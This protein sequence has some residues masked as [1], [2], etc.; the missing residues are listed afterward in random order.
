MDNP[1]A[2]DLS[3]LIVGTGILG[4]IIT[5]V[6]ALLGFVVSAFITSLWVRL[7]LVFMRGALD[8]EYGRMQM[9]GAGNRPSSYPSLAPPPAPLR[10]E[11][12]PRDW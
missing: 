10:N 5:I 2:P 12:A 11:Q 7:V 1:V 9:G 8:R 6:V 4:L 3:S